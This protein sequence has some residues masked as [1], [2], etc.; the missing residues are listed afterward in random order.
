MKLNLN[1]N[2]E[3]NLIKFLQSHENLNQIF[4]YIWVDVWKTV[5]DV[6]VVVWDSEIQEYLGTI[7][8]NISWFKQIEKFVV[9]LVKIWIDENN[10]F[11]CLWKYRTLYSWLYGLFW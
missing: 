3:K 9:N 5:L 1:Q 8:N 4:I 10:I 11:F 7:K 2:S 6:S